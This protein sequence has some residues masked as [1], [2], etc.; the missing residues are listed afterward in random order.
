[1][2]T[3]PEDDL[4]F[5]SMWSMVAGELSGLRFGSTLLK[6]AAADAFMNDKDE[7]ARFLK[8]LTSKIMIQ[9]NKKEEELYLCIN[10]NLRRAKCTSASGTKE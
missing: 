3:F 7:L 6:E 10:E 9:Q 1:M 2:T 8:S 4:E 5:H